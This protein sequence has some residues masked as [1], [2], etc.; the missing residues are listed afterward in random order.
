[1]SPE[2]HFSLIFLQFLK[3]TSPGH[4]Q[5][6]PFLFPLSDLSVSCLLPRKHISNI[7]SGWA[8][9]KIVTSEVRKCSQV[10]G[11]GF[12]SHSQYEPK[13]FLKL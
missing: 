11:R 4:P 2:T 10:S 7:S 5:N 12:N 1:M 3:Y 6:V 13:F 9:A 8:V